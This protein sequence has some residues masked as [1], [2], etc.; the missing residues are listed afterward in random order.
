MRLSNRLRTTLAGA[1]HAVGAVWAVAAL[2][3]LVFGV[4]VTFPL[5]PPLDLERVRV[6]PAFAAS[7]GLFMVGAI[8]GRIRN[9]QPPE[10]LETTN[11]PVLPEPAASELA[12]RPAERVRTTPQER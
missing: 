8:I 2:L 11:R 4:A 9:E 3:R 5:L 12:W 10:A 7:L 6:L 1:C